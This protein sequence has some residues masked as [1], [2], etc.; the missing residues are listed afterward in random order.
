M[1]F[2]KLKMGL[3]V[4]KK[5]GE[6]MKQRFLSIFLVL[7]LIIPFFPQVTLPAKAAETTAKTQDENSNDRDHKEG[8][9]GSITDG[10]RTGKKE[11]GNKNGF[12]IMDTAPVDAKGEGQKRYVAVLGYWLGGKR[13]ELY[14]ADKDGNRVSNTYAIG[15]EKTL[16][17]LEQADAF[18]D[19]GFVSV[20]AGDFN[21]DGKDTVIA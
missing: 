13:L 1:F 8:S 21:G 3:K 7:A 17:Y 9:I 16:D 20:A 6:S 11:E 5:G 2:V 19:T 12:T 18:E 14:I 4:S 15:G 10:T